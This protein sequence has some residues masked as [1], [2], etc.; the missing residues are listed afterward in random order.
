MIS[1][2]MLLN[3]MNHKRMPLSVLA[4]SAMTS[5]PQV[6]VNVPVTKKDGWKELPDIQEA[7]AKAESALGETGRVLVRASGTENLLRVMVEGK[8]QKE[9]ETMANA[10]A[11]V[12]RKV[13]GA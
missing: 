12:V 11:D 3:I 6:L 4:D 9:I 13:I 7:I 10:I 2:I 5:L 1:A 8:D